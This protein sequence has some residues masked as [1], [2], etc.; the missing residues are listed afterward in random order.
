MTD[1]HKTI[2]KGAFWSFLAQFGIKLIAFVYLILLARFAKPEQ[3]GVYYLALSILGILYIVTDLGL[4]YANNRYVPYLYARKE[5]K[6]LKFLIKFS[7]ITGGFL[8]FATSIVV[9]I[10]SKE[11]ANLA[12]Q[13]LVEPALKVLAFWLFFQEIYDISKGILLGKKMIKEA[14]V[15][16]FSPHIVKLILL[17]ILIWLQTVD[18]EILGITYILSFLIVCIPAVYYVSKIYGRLEVQD[19]KQFN[20]IEFGKEVIWFGLVSILLSLVTVVVESTDKILIGYFLGENALNDIATYTFGV[21]LAGLLLVFPVAI[22]TIFFPLASEAG[23]EDKEKL[24]RI[25]DLSIKW[26]AM[27]CIPMV[28]V[29]VIFSSE[30][31]RLLYGQIYEKGALVL[32][33]FSLALFVRALTMPLNSTMAAL[34][35][36]DIQMRI[37]SLLAVV[38]IVLNIM[39]IPRFGIIGAAIASL[40]ALSISTVLFV[41]YYKKILQVKIEFNFWKLFLAGLIVL[42]LVWGLK[43]VFKPTVDQIVQASFSGD[44]LAILILNKLI[45]IVV[46]SLLFSIVLLIYFAVLIL[47]KTFDRTEIDIVEGGLRRLGFSKDLIDKAVYIFEGKWII[48]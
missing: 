36:L 37:I 12:G 43:M 30:L 48:R 24:K 32:S 28:I 11:I 8:T 31:L 27:A 40:I 26:I 34:G 20:K 6:K 23:F 35:K 17:G 29:F 47:I 22:G 19:T 2:A 45:K 38:N 10:L 4:L 33:I 44:S 25:T 42:V 9:F 21:G 16:E 1:E 15:L 41:Y 7:Y 39:M 46:F 18:A 13:P 5:I 3:I 14:Q